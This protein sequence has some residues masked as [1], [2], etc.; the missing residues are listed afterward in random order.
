L[1]VITAP[2]GRAIITALLI[3][4]GLLQ[5]AWVWAGKKSPQPLQ[6]DI[7]VLPEA[8]HYLEL[9]AYPRPSFLPDYE[10]I[11]GWWFSVGE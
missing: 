11:E 1:I 5:P 10:I 7:P 6:F 4:S 8:E 2:F 3:V 9:L